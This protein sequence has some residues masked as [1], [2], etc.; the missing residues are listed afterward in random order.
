MAIIACCVKLAL[1][2]SAKLLEIDDRE[3]RID[4]RNGMTHLRLES[5]HVTRC[6][7]FNCVQIL[8]PVLK[9]LIARIVAY[10]R[11]APAQ[12]IHRAHLL[13]RSPIV[14]VFCHTDDFKVSGMLHIVA[15][16]LADRVA[17]L[18]VLFLEEPIHHRDI[19]RGWRV[20]LVLGAAFYDLRPD[21]VEVMRAGAQ[22]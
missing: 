8:R 21:G 2:C 11:S 13:R 16:V 4:L 6:L 3:I 18:E 9:F 20:L 12:K 17:V 5:R 19:A 14:R 22:P 10:E 7:N 15:E 1:T